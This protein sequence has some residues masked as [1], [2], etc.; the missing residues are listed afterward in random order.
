[1]NRLAFDGTRLLYLCLDPGV[2]LG[3][4]KGAAIHVAEMKR[5]CAALG[6]RVT[7]LARTI[8]PGVAPDNHVIPVRVWTRH[9]RR[10]GPAREL[11]DL[12]EL[13]ALRRV[14]SRGINGVRP[15]LVYERYSRF[16]AIGGEAARAASLPHVLEVNAPLA[17]EAARFRDGRLTRVARHYEERAWRETDLVVVPS[18]AM[19]EA[20]REVGQHNVL[21]VPN[22]VDTDRFRPRP[23]DEKLRLEL[24]IRDQFVLAF[25]GS[26]RPWHDLRTVVTALSGLPPDLRVSLLVI[27]NGPA[28]Q[29][30]LQLAQRLSVRCVCVD[31]VP[32][33]EVPRYLATA[34][35]AIASLGA[36]VEL[37]YF[38]PLKVTEY[39]A[40]GVPSIVACAGDLRLLVDNGVALGYA[41]GD[42]DDLRGVITLLAED[43]QLQERLRREGVEF[44][45]QRTWQAAAEEILGRMAPRLETVR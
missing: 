41:P 9:L 1:V 17:F 32:H 24:G 44:A 45:R 14:V 33:H 40:M 38:S 19:A 34:D 26:V 11:R 37:E 5:A 8:E 35:A 29:D 36:N 16:H 22:A 42:A 7:T 39:L 13:P 30:A 23:R 12:A 2:P 18:T 28:R 3:G 15:T 4:T 27:G 10:V 6:V 20:V 25:V 31:A 43:V 21:V